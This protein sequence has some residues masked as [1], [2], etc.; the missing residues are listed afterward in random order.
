MSACIL[1]LSYQLIKIVESFFKDLIAMNTQRNSK[2]SK[3]GSVFH[4]KTN[5]SYFRQ[6]DLAVKNL[7]ILNVEEKLRRNFFLMT[8]I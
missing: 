2:E 7:E 8:S 6:F 5:M 3:K 1:Y 4:I